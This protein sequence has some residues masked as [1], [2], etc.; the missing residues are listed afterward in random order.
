MGFKRQTS[1]IRN[2]I[3]PKAIKTG[4]KNKLV[5]P[6]GQFFLEGLISGRL[7]L[8]GE[9]WGGDSLSER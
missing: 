5:G 6:L 2:C 7:L 1:V 3:K 8:A 4:K 9:V